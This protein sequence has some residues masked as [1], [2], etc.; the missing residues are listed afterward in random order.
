MSLYKEETMSLGAAAASSGE[1]SLSWKDGKRR[2][3]LLS[4][5]LPV[6]GALLLFLAYEFDAGVLYWGFFFVFY[7]LVPLLDF[8]IGTDR[9]NPPEAAVTQLVA[10]RYYRIIIYAY[11]PSQYAVTIFGAWLAVNGGLLWW[12]MLGLVVSVGMVNGIGI[13]TAHELGHKTGSAERWLAKVA[14]APVAYGHFFIEHNK[15]HHKNVATPND[16][17]SSKMGETFWRFLPRTMIGSLRSAWSIEKLRLARKGRSAWSLDNE[18]LQ[19]WMMSVALFGALAIWLG[20]WVLLFLFAQALYGATLLEVVNYL[21]HYGLLR[22]LEASGRRE[23]CRPWHS[24][25]S[26][27]IVTNLVLYQLQRHS[28]HHANPTRRYQALRHFDNC[29]QLPS[30][31][32]S[33]LL[34]A[35]LPPLWFRIMDPLVVAHYEGDL[36]RANLL[37][38]RREALI[39]KWMGDA[40]STV[41]VMAPARRSA[42]CSGVQKVSETASYRC[43]N[44]SYTYDP[45]SGCPS[46]GIPAGTAWRRVPDDWSCPDCAVRDKVDFVPVER[47]ADPAGALAFG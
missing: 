11:I 16:P 4:P 30:G 27:H 40:K 10:D 6:L 2:L 7:A 26:N 37:P 12:E 31:Y 46:E 18:N 1:G 13:N 34:V 35:Y 41:P 45:S 29:P 14:L 21:E 23:R 25:N 36:T 3:W 8:L 24:W 15:G 32:A 17:A 22:Q 5:A 47:T 20:P 9:V 38:S 43:P 28:D 42:A 33:M 44:C 39:R 19:A